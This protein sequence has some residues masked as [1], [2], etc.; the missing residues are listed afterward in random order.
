MKFNLPGE[1]MKTLEISKL[2]NSLANN[3]NRRIKKDASP[4][5]DNGFNKVRELTI[6]VTNKCNLTCKG[7]GFNVPNQI[8]PV[9]GNDIDQHILSLKLLKKIGV[10]LG[11]LVIV[12]GEA[13]LAKALSDYVS[14]VK[15]VGIA[16]KIE[17]VTN[18]LYPH[19]LT[20]QVAAQLDSLVFS[21]YICT[22]SFESTWVDYLSLI[23]YTGE[24]DFRRKE[25]WDDLVSVV[26]NVPEQVQAHWNTCF[27]R[28][29]DVTL[30]RGRLFSCSRIAKKN[31][32]EQGLLINTETTINDVKE[33]L[34]S[35]SPKQACYSCA[36]VGQ[37]SNIPVAEQVST[38]LI[39]LAQKAESFM[40]GELNRE[41]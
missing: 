27:Y 22:D 3:S 13:T 30:E 12:G 6:S 34:L 37:A 33:Y 18:G 8:S 7:C 32:N 4:F 11:K 14:Q 16:E 39:K 28:K 19:G 9:N 41:E 38:N 1:T 20:V 26:S 2:I 35:N 24:L 29:Y 40:N 23:G 25:A 17:L 31:L 15:S 10:K 5:S 21:D 36:T